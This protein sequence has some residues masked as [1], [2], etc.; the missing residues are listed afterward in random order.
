MKPGVQGNTKMF[1][2]SPNWNQV[3]A[4]TANLT[5]IKRR[6]KIIITKNYELNLTVALFM[7]GLSVTFFGQPLQRYLIF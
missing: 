7:T 1:Q 6:E 4:I 3:T 2:V 5:V